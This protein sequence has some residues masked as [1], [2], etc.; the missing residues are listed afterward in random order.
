[1]SDPVP[2][3]IPLWLSE[4]DAVYLDGMVAEG[5]FR[6]RAEL[7]RSLIRAIIDDDKATHGKAA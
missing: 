2:V 5:G 6:C 4:A 1:M 7:V 3:I